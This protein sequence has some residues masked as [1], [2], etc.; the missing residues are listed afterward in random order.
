M[1]PFGEPT[2]TIARAGS[3]AAAAAAR[4]TRLPAGHPEGYLEAFA[5]IYGEIAHAI[6]ARRKGGAKADPAVEFPGLA[7]GLAGVEFIAAAVASAQG[8]GRWVRLPAGGQPPPLK[9]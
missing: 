8:G 9:P 1:S 4:V 2:Q 5:T 3:A 6:R 7:D